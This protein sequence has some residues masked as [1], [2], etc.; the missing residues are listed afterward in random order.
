[1]KKVLI[2]TYHF[3]PEGGAGVQRA[4]KFVRYLPNFGYQ[5]FVLTSKHKVKLHDVSLTKE[6]QENHIY[7]VTDLGDRIPYDLKNIFSRYLQ[8]DKRILWKH[9][10]VRK[11]MDIIQGNGINLILSTSPPHSVHLIAKR[12]AEEFQLPWVADFRD[13]WTT[14]LHLSS[15]KYA[16]MHQQLEKDIL[17]SA[18]YITTVRHSAKKHFQESNA[19]A[20]VIYNGFDPNDFAKLNSADNQ[21]VLDNKKF[22]ILYCGSFT[23]RSSPIKLFDELE[24]IISG[25]DNIKKDLSL[26]VVGD[27]RSNIRR[28]KNHPKLHENVS[29]ID[30]QPHDICLKLM[31]G[32]GVLLLLATNEKGMDI[33]PGKLFEY[34]YS[35]KPI[36]AIERFESEL[37]GMLESY[38]NYYLA[39]EVEEGSVRKTIYHLYDDWKQGRLSDSLN[40]S[41]ISRFNREHLTSELAGVFDQLLNEQ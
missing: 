34:F 30:Y 33:L 28:L 4:L 12:V 11:A 9:T 26:T 20:K 32:A 8:P 2:I 19:H 17:V 38:G 40:D 13:E 5:P 25:D 18:D 41:F 14:D 6:I 29:F 3:P 37:D 1:M 21:N 39:H 10:A 35:K 22:N 27:K 24:T 36:F 15:W 7:R 16:T 31:Q 23:P